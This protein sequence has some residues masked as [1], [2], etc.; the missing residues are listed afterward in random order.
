MG[1]DKTMEEEM[2]IKHDKLYSWRCLRLA[3]KENF[4]L[5][6]KSNNGTLNNV[7]KELKKQ[8]EKGKE[9]HSKEDTMKDSRN[10][11][12]QH[13][14]GKKRTRDETIKTNPEKLN[15]I[16]EDQEVNLNKKKNKVEQDTNKSDEIKKCDVH[17]EENR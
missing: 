14:Q 5:F 12:S 11:N 16:K 1:D 7:I 3:S 10:V 2:K 17:K 8:K 4:P 13:K 9:S 15:I 6:L